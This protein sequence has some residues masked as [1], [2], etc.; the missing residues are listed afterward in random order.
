MGGSIR[1]VVKVKLKS[2][3]FECPIVISLGGA[4][5][6]PD[7]IN[8]TFIYEFKKFIL[9]QVNLNRRFI[10]VCGGGKTARNYQ[11]AYKM[12]VPIAD[13]DTLDWIGINATRFNAE[14]IASIF[15]DMAD[16][17]IIIDPNKKIATRKPI[18]FAGGYKPG[19]STDNVAVRLA[20]KVGATQIVNLSDIDC[21]YDTDPKGENGKKA[22][23]IKNISWNEYLKIIPEEFTA[24]G[25]YPFSPEASREAK[26]LG[27][28]VAITNGYNLA[29]F[30]AYL[31]PTATGSDF[32]G[33]R[34]N[35]I[36]P[37]EF[38][39][40]NQRFLRKHILPPKVIN[41]GM[42]KSLV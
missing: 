8:T 29:D 18:V 24:G 42:T 19:G 23:R 10:I 36:L 33:T 27:L 9:Q 2:L 5:I 40:A 16:Q 3:D 21:V 26:R 39:P 13:N 7:K 22:K 32:M 34:I 28:E 25:N 1:G 41:I 37:L 30:E 12:L 35:G 4:L 11:N 38:H 14:F 15:G 6:V 31:Y 17:N 20:S